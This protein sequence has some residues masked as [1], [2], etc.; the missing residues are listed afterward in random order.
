[1]NYFIFKFKMIYFY[2]EVIS[3]EIFCYDFVSFFSLDTN[4]NKDNPFKALI[5]KNHSAKTE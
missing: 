1:M 5:T 3:A 2:A 4:D